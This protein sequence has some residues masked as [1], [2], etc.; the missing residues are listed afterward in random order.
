M[1]LF[2][3]KGAE[4]RTLFSRVPTL[5]WFGLVWSGLPTIRGWCSPVFLFHVCVPVPCSRGYQRRFGIAELMSFPRADHPEGK[6][7]SSKAGQYH[8]NKTREKEQKRRDLGGRP[9]SSNSGVFSDNLGNR[10]QKTGKQYR[11]SMS[12]SEHTRYL[13]RAEAL[14]FNKSP[15]SDNNHGN[16]SG[17]WTLHSRS[18][19]SQHRILKPFF[20]LYLPNNFCYY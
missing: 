6:W 2:P 11:P 14:V 19:H 3:A 16:I 20:F 5:F 4:E 18:L 15:V 10:K 13:S 9:Q 17:V 8:G 12:I 1:C 7:S